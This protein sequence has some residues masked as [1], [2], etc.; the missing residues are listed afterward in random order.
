MSAASRQRY[1]TSSSWVCV[2]KLC[3]EL[4]GNIDLDECS[5]KATIFYFEQLGL[6]EVRGN[7]VSLTEK[8]KAT[9]NLDDLDNDDPPKKQ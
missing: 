4:N 9:K 1:S 8:G 3:L 6:L 7:M 5:F 2:I